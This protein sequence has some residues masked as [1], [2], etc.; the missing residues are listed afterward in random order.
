M[1]ILMALSQREVTGAEVY[2]TT[3]S[4]ELISRGNK[5]YLI[6]DTLSTPT[7]AQYIKLEFNK[8]SLLHRMKHVITLYKVIKKY[9]IHII[10]AHSRASSWS[11]Q[12][13]CKLAGIPLIT[14]THGR[15]KNH[16]SRRLIKAFGQHSITVCENIRDNLKELGFAEEKMTVL[17]N[18]VQ[19][20]PKEIEKF[21]VEKPIISIIGRL[22][23]P[24]GDVAYDILRI[25]TDKKLL[26]HYQVRVIGGRDLPERFVEF[27]Q[28]GVEFLG[29]IHDVQQ[30]MSESAVVIGAGRVAIESMQNKTP[31]I[32]VGESEYVGLVSAENMSRALASNFGDIGNL[33]YP[34]ITSEQLL[35]DIHQSQHISAEQ[36]VYL[37]QSIKSETDLTHIVDTIERK[38]FEL[39]VDYTK[40]EVPILMYHR[41]IKSE[42]QKGLHGTYLML[43]KFRQQM[44]YLKVRGYTPINFTD[45]SRLWRDRFNVDKKYVMITFDDGYVD[46]YEI[47][48][49]VLKEFGFTATIFLLAESTYNEW[50]VKASGEKS[51]PLMNKEMI[52]EMQSVD[53]EFGAHTFNHPKLPMLSEEEITRQI[54]DCKAVLEEKLGKSIN[55]FAYPYGLL[56]E[57][58]KLAAKQAGYQ[59]AVA[60]DS[61]PVCLS[62]DFYQIRRIGIF[63]KNNLWNFMRKIK[64]N[65]NF[66]KIAREKRKQD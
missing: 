41:I 7:K 42:E 12:I 18:P 11:C 47:A 21:P 61:G 16:F 50:D 24:K 20:L 23:G 25:L 10:H 38:Y 31:L 43:D 51:F 65:Y 48:F 59:F 58:A 30:K 13:A 4:D 26:S 1:N 5:V 57:T 14:T 63:P 34:H 37:Q 19:F 64:G 45:L 15:Q 17:R 33:K 35:S 32:A 46:N 55:V 27:Q 3:I 6:S 49:P 22:S 28:K 36:L 39:Y 44:Q 52:L 53:I 62:E 66:I 60:T 40:R 8:R 2:A 56:N 29:H 9:D 54:V